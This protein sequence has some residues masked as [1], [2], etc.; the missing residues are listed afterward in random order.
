MIMT[1][2]NALTTHNQIHTES[3]GLPTLITIIT[4]M[5]TI[6]H[7]IMLLSYVGIMLNID[8]N[9]EPIIL[10]CSGH[11]WCQISVQ[12]DGKC[13]FKFRFMYIFPLV[14]L[15]YM[16]ALALTFSR[17]ITNIFPMSLLDVWHLP[18]KEYSVYCLKGNPIWY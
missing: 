10:D 14:D 1:P 15:Y 2:L 4:I 17:I 18:H 11:G 7:C 3:L 5:T 12:V 9:M 16:A 8:S 6:T 13:C